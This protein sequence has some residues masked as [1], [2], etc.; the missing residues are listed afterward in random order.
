[1]WHNAQPHR[2][3]PTGRAYSDSDYASDSDTRRSVTGT[4]RDQPLLWTSSRQKSTTHSSTES[5]YIAADVAARQLVWISHLAEQ[6]RIPLVNREPSIIISDKPATKY[7]EGRIVCDERPYLP[8]RVY[9]TGAI[10]IAQA[11]GPT[12]RAKHLDVR[13]RYLQ[14][15]VTSK[16]DQNATSTNN[17]A[18]C[19]CIYQARW[20][21]QV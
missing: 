17:N 9:N 15:L 8:L 6:R 1:M 14:K 10:A 12:R 16:N 13:H 5:E 7:H 3:N 2:S 4:A 18:T 11:N 19:C 21:S 20:G